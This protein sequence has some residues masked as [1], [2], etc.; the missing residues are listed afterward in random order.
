MFRTL[1]LKKPTKMKLFVVVSILLVLVLCSVVQQSEAGLLKSA[2]K[3]VAG[4]RKNARP[5]NKAKHQKG[6]ARRQADQNRKAKG[7][8]KK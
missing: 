8:K 2:F 5:S 1:H 7:P 4:H 6:N 3:K